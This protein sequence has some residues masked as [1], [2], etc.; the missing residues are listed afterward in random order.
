MTCEVAILN[1][2][3]VA[4]AADSAVTFS[5]AQTTFATGA[6]KIFQLSEVAPV[7]VMI[8]NGAALHNVPWELILK[9]FR[10]ELDCTTHHSLSQ[11]SDALV[12]FIQSNERLFPQAVR[13]DHFKMLCAISARKFIDIALTMQPAISNREDEAGWKAAWQVAFAMLE[14]QVTDADLHPPFD[15]TDVSK[16]LLQNSGWLSDELER[17]LLGNVG[18]SHLAEV[19][20]FTRTAE[21]SIVSVFKFID[22]VVG[23]FYTGVVLA[24]FGSEDYFPSCIE[25]RVAGFVQDRFLVQYGKAIEIDHSYG[26]EIQAFAMKTTVETFLQGVSPR[27]WSQAQSLFAGLTAKCCSDVLAS[28]GA[29]PPDDLEEILARA[30]DAFEETWVQNVLDDHYNPLR[31]VISSLAVDQMAELAENLVML[32]SLKEKVTSRT[33]SVGGPIDVAVI[34]KSEGLVWI[35]RKLFFSPELNHRYFARHGVSRG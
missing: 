33:Q 30:R 6:N 10:A 15:E 20:D 1:R 16:A 31:Q 11:Y 12:S 9:S 29:S 14:Q 28:A 18:I 4:L 7:G 26:A 32:E 23:N 5:E 8:F 25:L 21:L 13:D 34:T 27:V 24:G 35:K 19:M 2:M 17:Y 3:G 22:K